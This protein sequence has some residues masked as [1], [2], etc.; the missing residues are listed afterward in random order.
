MSKHP[1]QASEGGDN[2]YIHPCDIYNG[3]RHYA[4][5][6][7]IINKQESGQ[8]NLWEANCNAAIT[9]RRC[10]AVAMRDKEQ[11][12][13]EALY[14]APREPSLLKRAKDLI[15]DRSYQIGWAKPG[16]SNG[17]KAPPLAQPPS[18]PKA[19]SKKKAAPEPKS[20]GSLHADLINKLM[21]EQR[22]EE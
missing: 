10:P 2:S 18:T 11:D 20:T 19:V 8:P 6:L 9:G 5:C 16:P 17:P 4:V 14:Y 1:P 21:Q 12:A 13:G 7:N 15:F 3:R 22:N